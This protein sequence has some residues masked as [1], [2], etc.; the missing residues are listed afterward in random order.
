[1][2]VTPKVILKRSGSEFIVHDKKS[3]RSFPLKGYGA[4]KGQIVFRNDLDLTKPIAE[5]VAKID[6]HRKRAALK[7]SKAVA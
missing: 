4:L 6:F 1:M 3:G 7:T 2:A 5:Q